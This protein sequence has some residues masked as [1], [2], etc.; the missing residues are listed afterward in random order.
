MIENLDINDLDS[1]IWKTIESYQ[2][3]QI[4]NF[5]RIKSFKR[6]NRTNK[7][8]LN[9]IKNSSGYLIIDLSKN[10]KRKIKFIHRLMYETFIGVIPEGYD[11][12]HKDFT[13]NNYLDNFKLIPKSEH[14]R[15][16]KINY[17]PSI[18]TKNKISEATKGEKNPNSKLS[19]KQ[20]IQIHKLIKLGFKNIEISKIYEVN[21]VNI[22]DI[23]Y[24]RIW[25][26]IYKQF[27][28]EVI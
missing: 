28:K 6:Y 22:C 18:K 27:Y 14:H 13:K 5:G 24:G 26:Y 9:T 19:E 3:Y 1:E 10:G 16:H 8:I 4:S 21:P 11:V 12:H 20:V 17:H 2:D 15:L 25:N 23:K 7:N